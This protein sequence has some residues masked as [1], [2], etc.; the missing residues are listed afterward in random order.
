[1]VQPSKA[2]QAGIKILPAGPAY[3]PNDVR[4][5]RDM[6]KNFLAVPGLIDLCC[7]KLF[8]VMVTDG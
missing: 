3:R 6:I 5:R 2:Q 4:Q 7:E 8:K 1:M